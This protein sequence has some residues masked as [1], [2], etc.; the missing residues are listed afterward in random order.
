VT[1]FRFA[2]G[3]AQELYGVT[4]DLCALGKVTGGG[5]PLSAVAGREEFMKYFDAQEVGMEK[6]VKQIGTLSG[7]PVATAAGLATL[8]ILQTPG[9]FENLFSTGQKLMDGL[10]AL[11]AKYGVKGQVRGVPSMFDILFTDADVKD[12]RSAAQSN[13]SKL[14]VFNEQ[15]LLPSMVTP[16][17]D[18]PF[19][20]SC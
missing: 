17:F 11:I 13:S 20:G 19:N 5:Y 15:V 10:T 2:Y 8:E 12:Y 18:A 14:K 16:Q 7:N 1:G 9:T 4:P 6:A 3:G